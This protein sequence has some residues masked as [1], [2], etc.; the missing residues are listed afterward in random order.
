MWAN[1]LV[2]GSVRTLE[3]RGN[4]VGLQCLLGLAADRAVSPNAWAKTVPLENRNRQRNWGVGEVLRVWNLKT[5]V[6]R[7]ASLLPH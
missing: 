6:Q 7:A 5:E 4:G 2:M 3:F 1:A